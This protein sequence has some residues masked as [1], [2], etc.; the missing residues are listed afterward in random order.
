M[1]RSG[2]ARAA[3]Q[4]LVSW[5]RSWA[6]LSFV[7]Y[8]FCSLV[9]TYPLVLQLGTHVPGT[10]AGDVP[11]YIWNLWW[12]RFAFLTGTS[13]LFSEYIFAPYGVSLVFHA[14]VFFKAVL[15]IPLQEVFSTW[16]SYNLLILESFAM[17]AF[18]MYLLARY[19]T[20]NQSAAWVAGLIYGFSPYMLARGTGHLNYLSGEWIPLYA[21]C[22][23]R[24]IDE[25]RARWAVCGGI[26]L[27]FTAYCEYYYLIYLSIFSAVLIAHRL[28][29]ESAS[30]LRWDLVR[31]IG[32]MGAIPTIGFSP[33]LWA[34]FTASDS[35]FI[36]GGWSGS[37]K[38][39]ADLLAFVV[40]P[41]G[42]LLYGDIGR[43]LY[44]EFTGGNRIEGTVFI[45]FTALALT[46]W[47]AVRLRCDPRVRPWFWITLLFWL[48]SLGPLLHIGG[49]FVFGL[50]SIRFSV[51]LPYFLVHYIPLIKGARVP[52]RFDIMVNL[53]IAVL[54]AF[55]L[56]H[57][58]QLTIK[59]W[60]AALVFSLIVALEH[61]RLPYPTSEVEIP[62][63]YREIAKDSRDV[64]VMDIPIGWRTGWGNI[65]RSHDWQQLY[66][67]VHKKRIIGGFASRVPQDELRAMRELPGIASL[68][69][70][71]E[72]VP[73]QPTPTGLRRG[74]I[75]AQI[76]E[77]LDHLPEM[78]STR[79]RKNPSL[80]QFLNSPPTGALPVHEMPP[81]GRADGNELVAAT[82]LGYIVVHSPYSTLAPLISYL[83]R[84]WS[85]RQ[86]YQRD[87]IIAYAIVADT[88]NN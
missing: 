69:M 29:F 64:A 1:I 52:A 56:R 81:V 72:L 31:L 74:V 83:E 37:A 58:L 14:F 16:T 42:G 66:Q 43:D 67:I 7:A 22:L 12:T 34:L 40:P 55:A 68:L 32:L 13:P 88:S 77:L 71:Q 9:F 19:L 39:G 49:D 87:G 51:P 78:V 47:C 2:V 36:Y 62:D 30:I 53:G 23:L 21:L 44:T 54:S 45:G 5:Y 24:L 4:Q 20:A 73:A 41:A 6:F 82:Q 48:L 76:R 26:C 11:V 15:A 75:R 84:V 79:L 86:F 80:R 57:L 8:L 10:V 33:I 65:G 35:G 3:I 70:L 27:L 46:A 61:L 85:L 38:M 25:R 63:V 59:A 28:R 50:G 17:S 18:F 60:P